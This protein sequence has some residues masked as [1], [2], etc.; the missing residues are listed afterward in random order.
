MAVTA[1]QA[2][3]GTRPAQNLRVDR[4][5]LQPALTAAGLTAFVIYSTWSTFTPHDYFAGAAVGRDYLSPFFSPC[6]TNRCGAGATWHLV[7]WWPFSAAILMLPFPLMFRGTCYYYRKAYYRSFWLSPPACAVPEPHGKYTGESRFPL[8]IQNLHR[9]AFYLTF[10]FPIILLWEAWK[11]TR[12][13]TVSGTGA[14]VDSRG[15]ALGT[16]VLFVNAILLGTYLLSCHSG[17][18]LCGGH[19]NAMSKGPTR[20]WLWRRVSFLNQHHMGLAWVS[21]IFVALTD[22]Y[23]RLVASGAIHDPR[24]F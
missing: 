5:W 21:L 11:G 14:L 3:R 10:P 15:L 20:Y 23:V 24:F 13:I 22:V 16:L 17:R 4:W 18:H 7:N 12:M 9:Y 2:G 8:L 1:V 19:L 6:I